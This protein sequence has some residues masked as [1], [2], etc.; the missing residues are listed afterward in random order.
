VVALLHREDNTDRSPAQVWARELDEGRYLCSQATMY[1]I[2]LARGETKERR[3]QA[4]HPPK[5]R[6]EL[7]A[8]G[9]VEVFTWDITK[10]KGPFRG[11]YYDL[12]VMLDIFSRYVVGWT[13]QDTETGELAVEFIDQVIA[14]HGTPKVIHAD[15]GT[16]MTSKSVAK[17]LGDLDI[18]RSHSRPHV[19]N[20]NPYSEAQFKT[21]KYCPAFPDY[22]DSIDHARA[23]CV[24]FFNY[25]NH[26]HRH[27]ALG[28]HTPASVHFGTAL[29]I[30]VRRATVLEAAYA[31][32]P[33]RFGRRPEP[34]KLP[35]AAWINPPSQAAPVQSA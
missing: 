7:V 25:Y 34:P 18:T 31:R 33:E 11:E 19:S 8:H 22:F 15:R 35:T 10:L 3:R 6:P 14:T 1:R 17:L 21:L 4:T 27:S 2:L 28:L 24:E 16:S 23:F 13:V 30:Q 5:T 29:T 26:D 32:N 12:Y 9:P 20:D